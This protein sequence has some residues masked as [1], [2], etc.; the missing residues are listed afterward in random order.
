[1]VAY[2][3]L[4]ENTYQSGQTVDFKLYPDKKGKTIV[5]CFN[6]SKIHIGLY[7]PSG[8]DTR[9][10]SF[11]LERIL[12]CKMAD[13]AEVLY[14]KVSF[15]GVTV[16]KWTSLNSSHTMSSFRVESQWTTTFGIKKD[17]VFKKASEVSR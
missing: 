17:R 1:M 10:F 3:A 2:F 16:E 15:K 12:A 11:Y 4:T 9:D 7:E 6:S 5:G 13:L 8:P 14:A